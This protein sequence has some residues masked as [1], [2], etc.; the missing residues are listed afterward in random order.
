MKAL[1]V[2]WKLRPKSVAY[3]WQKPKLC[4]RCWRRMER[5]PLSLARYACPGCGI[6]RIH[7]GYVQCSIEVTRD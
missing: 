7:G 5:R 3:W 1:A 4:H 2:L 6:E